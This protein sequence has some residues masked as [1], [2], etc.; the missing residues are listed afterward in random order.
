M[1][2]SLFLNWVEN[3][4][5]YIYT[6]IELVIDVLFHNE[7]RFIYNSSNISDVFEGLEDEKSGAI[8]SN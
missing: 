7:P 6:Y 4:Y 2:K 1:F 5:I 3:L 8:S